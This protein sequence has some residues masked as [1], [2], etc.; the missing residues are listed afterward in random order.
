MG[1]S[2]RHVDT[3]Q[4]ELFGIDDVRPA[5]PVMRPPGEFLDLHFLVRNETGQGH[6]IPPST[7]R[8][9]LGS[10]KASYQLSN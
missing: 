4:K 2:R 8:V 1:L 9:L 5:Q 10:E 3:H 7:R 6:G